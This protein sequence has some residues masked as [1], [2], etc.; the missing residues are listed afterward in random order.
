[1]DDPH[2][3]HH[4]SLFEDHGVRVGSFGGRNAGGG[5]ARDGS[6]GKLTDHSNTSETG[7]DRLTGAQ[8]N[9]RPAWLE[10]LYAV[11]VGVG[12]FVITVK[13]LP[14]IIAG[15]IVMGVL[16]SLTFAAERRFGHRREP[17]T[18][19]SAENKDFLRSLIF[20]GVALV[21]GWYIFDQSSSWD[22]GQ[23]MGSCAVFAAVAFVFFV[24]DDMYQKRRFLAESGVSSKRT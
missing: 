18:S 5:S 16:G 7:A 24:G 17:S 11:V 1:M 21:A 8:V 13:V 6:N 10:A 20:L 12:M 9:S 3:P 22:I 14:G 4:H 23:R 15:V 19:G 2:V